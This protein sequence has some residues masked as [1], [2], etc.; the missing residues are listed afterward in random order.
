ML[1]SSGTTGRPKGI[2]PP[3]VPDTPIDQT[4]VLAQ[5][6]QAFSGAGEDSVYLS[7]AP[8]YHAAPLRYCMTFMKLG[9]TL[10]IMEKLDAEALLGYIQKY[11]VRHRQRVRTMFGKLRKL[12]EEVRR[13]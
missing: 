3:L 5:V 1:Y 13:K 9:A 12:P 2:R 4:N 6:L 8:L 10:I 7:P 11:K